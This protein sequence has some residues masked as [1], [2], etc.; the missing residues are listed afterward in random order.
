[1]AA[2]TSQFIGYPGSPKD[3]SS[4]EAMRKRQKEVDDNAAKARTQKE[5]DEIMKA[6]DVDPGKYLPFRI[7]E[8]KGIMAEGVDKILKAAAAG[9]YSALQEAKNDIKLRSGNFVDEKRAV[10]EAI[11]SAETG[12]TFTAADLRRLYSGKGRGDFEDMIKSGAI[13]VHEETGRFIP[14]LYDNVDI[15]NYTLNIVKDYKNLPTG[16][17]DS[18]GR[19]IYETDVEGLTNALGMTW[20][21]QPALAKKFTL[22]NQDRIVKEGKSPEQINN[23]L[24][25]MYINQGLGMPV[26]SKRTNRPGD[27]TNIFNL[28]NGTE[29]PPAMKSIG[30]S[31]IKITQTN[32]FTGKKEVGAFNL[33]NSRTLGDAVATIPKGVGSYYADT[34]ESVTDSDLQK[35]TFNEF[36]NALVFARDVT[37]NTPEGRVTYK[38]GTPIL[39][40]FETAAIQNGWAKPAMVVSADVDGRYILSDARRF[41]Q[42]KAITASKDDT[43][44]INAN[45]NEAEKDFEQYEK[46]FKKREVDLKKIKEGRS[47]KPQ[48]NTKPPAKTKESASKVEAKKQNAAKIAKESGIKPLR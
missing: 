30:L 45:L 1:M 31:E 16:K 22:L 5:L 47:T 3:Y 32:P 7:P 48:T 37:T 20:D 35:A 29:T 2:T 34:G 38:K 36:G 39:Q 19:F 12:A 10:D 26:P 9:D 28:G 15:P 33:S 14:T 43:P 13:Q 23:E 40:G 46:D 4:L 42:T 18:F 6:T 25:Q 17:T 44:V 11:K 8:V 27:R 41:L 21:N 24:R